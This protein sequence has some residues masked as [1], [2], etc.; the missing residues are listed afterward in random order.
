MVG[1]V[2]DSQFLAS[3]LSRVFAG[4]V[5]DRIG[6]KRAVI[7]GLLAA[8]FSGALS[9]ASLIIGSSAIVALGEGDGTAGPASL[10]M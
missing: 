4:H 6:P 8:I 9:L 10:G 3:I 7:A 2:A 1:L 5:A